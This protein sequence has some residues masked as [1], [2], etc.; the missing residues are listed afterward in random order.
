MADST[1]SGPII[2]YCVEYAETQLSVC[3]ACNRVIPAKSLRVGELFRKNKK[4]KKK[5]AK[6]SWW[7]FKC[8]TV[9]KMLTVLPIEQFRGFPALAKKDQ[10][11]VERVIKHGEGASWK[12]V[13]V[14]VV[15]EGEEEEVEE[16]KPKKKQKISKEADE[17]VDLT[18]ILTGVQ[19]KKPETKTKKAKD[20]VNGEKTKGEK[21]KTEKATKKQA[22]VEAPKVE[23]EPKPVLLPKEDQLELESIANEIQASFKADQ[24]AKRSRA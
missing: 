11:R 3:K 18:D 7:H 14:K 8:W 24:K 1:S 5:Q 20:A 19:A 21:K 4:E 16:E 6:Y 15:K 17:D 2:T 12:S 10:E 22:K 9:P 13:N 23:E